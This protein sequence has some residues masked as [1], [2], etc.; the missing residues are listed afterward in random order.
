MT[1][2]L[3]VPLLLVLGGAAASAQPKSPHDPVPLAPGRSLPVVAEHRYTVSARIRPLLFFWISRDNVGEAL[4]R[5][6]AGA[7]K[8][9]GFELLIGSDPARAPRHVNQWGYIAEE[10]SSDGAAL[11]GVMKDSDDKTL[12]EA[13]KRVES[14]SGRR[15]FFYKAIRTSVIQ[16]KGT[17]GT[18]RLTL[19][20][21]PTFRDLEWVLE[22]VPASPPTPREYPLAPGVKPGY[23]PTLQAVVL[24]SVAWHQRGEPAAGSPI[25]RVVQY[26]FNG[27]TYDLVLRSSKRVASARYRGRPFQDLIE[28]EMAITNRKTSERTQFVVQYPRAGALAGVPVHGVFRPRWWFEVEMTMDDGTGPGAGKE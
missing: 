2:R 6:R 7:D 10:V 3:A 22:Q 18:T 11:L 23:L 27:T 24:D 5:W 20:R 1:A 14:E 4:L 15:Q 26:V 9:L 28:A 25:G 21:D 13:Q 8:Q 16:D 19:A 17:T 12:E